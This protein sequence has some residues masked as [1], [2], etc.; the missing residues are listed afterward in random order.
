[1]TPILFALL[2]ACY[3][4]ADA[5]LDGCLD[6]IDAGRETARR[7]SRDCR[8]I[9]PAVSPPEE[10]P[11]PVAGHQTEWRLGYLT[12]YPSAYIGAYTVTDCWGER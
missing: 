10:A 12:C 6:G 4:P 8:A 1:M 2:F 5:E 3:S 7:D 11:Y 9:D